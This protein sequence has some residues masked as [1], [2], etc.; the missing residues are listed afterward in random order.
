MSPSPW[1]RMQLPS[2]NKVLNGIYLA[3]PS[4]FPAVDFDY[5]DLMSSK[6]G[7]VPFQNSN[8]ILGVGEVG[9]ERNEWARS[10][11]VPIEMTGYF[12]CGKVASMT[13]GV[14]TRG[15]EPGCRG[16]VV[17]PIK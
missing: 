15:V 10:P 13:A 17:D 11:A 3:R 12:L 4:Q 7:V 1:R 5:L 6:F 16:E 9:E 2:I 8:P 14:E